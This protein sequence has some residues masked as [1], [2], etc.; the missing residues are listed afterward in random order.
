MNTA[1]EIVIFTSQ[2][3]TQSP[4]LLAGY[5]AHCFTAYREFREAA[6]KPAAFVFKSDDERYTGTLL[7]QLRRDPDHATALAFIDG[8]V[9]ATDQPLT[10]GVMPSNAPALLEH[11][12]EFQSRAGSIRQTGDDQSPEASLLKYMWLR[13]GYVLEPLADWR[14]PRGYHY[15][16]LE[17]LDRSESDPDLCLQKMDRQG[18]LE[19]VE[20]KDRQ[21]E[22]DHCGSAHLSFIDVCPT[23]RSIDIDQHAAL[24][25]FNCG[26]IAPETRFVRGSQRYCPKCTSQL[27]HIG[28][29]YDRPLETCVCSSCDH[30]FV[31]GDVVARCA[32]CAHTMSPTSLRLRKLYS[33][34]LSSAGRL[35][36]QDGVTSETKVEGHRHASRDQY[37]TAL[38]LMIKIARG[39]SDFNFMLMG[40]RLKN[41]AALESGLGVSSAARLVN[42]YVERLTE[43]IDDAD[44]MTRHDE[45][46]IL[47]ILPGYDRKR[48]ARLR[49]A[50]KTLSSQAKQSDGAGPVWDVVE[51]PVTSKIVNNENA[52]AILVRLHAMLEERMAQAA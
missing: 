38:D 17:A 51:L 47:F 42:A 7:R 41:R 10:D 33:W 13:P 26:L 46:T 6:I 11:I 23:C 9:S 40:L 31:E 22:C 5:V 48:L 21:R 8:T 28:T 1:N 12:G 3:V 44:L 34:R 45:E 24:H 16:V 19:R 37:S 29:D 18:Y 15:P 43:S 14:H 35:A 30:V 27:R 39:Q 20:L 52:D 2:R 4:V 50:I 36:A 25:C 32:I 49:G